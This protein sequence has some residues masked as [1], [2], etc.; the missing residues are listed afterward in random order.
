MGRNG[1]F[2]AT[3]PFERGLNKDCKCAV[4]I[5]C[6][7]TYLHSSTNL[8]LGTGL[9]GPGSGVGSWSAR[10]KKRRPSLLELTDFLLLCVSRALGSLLSVGLAHCRSIAR[11]S[12]E[13]CLE[14]Y[15]TLALPWSVEGTVTGEEEVGRAEGL[16]GFLEE[17][18]HSS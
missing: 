5:Y 18:E 4:H 13:C 14:S 11:W 9:L 6:T 10:T 16:R 2:S 7:D 8:Q 17:A 15:P 12:E 3:F 1:P